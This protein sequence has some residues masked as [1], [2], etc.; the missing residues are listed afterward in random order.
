MIFA[1]SSL[2]FPFI[3]DP[4]FALGAALRA[5]IRR[6]LTQREPRPRS[7]AP[8]FSLF[9]P[10]AM[11]SPAREPGLYFSRLAHAPSTL[12]LLKAPKPSRE[13]EAHPDCSP[14][15]RLALASPRLGGRACYRPFLSSLA[16]LPLLVAVAAASSSIL[17]S[18][19]SAPSLPFSVDGGGGSLAS[20]FKNLRAALGNQP[21]DSYVAAYLALFGRPS[22]SYA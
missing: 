4:P 18:P 14:P 12:C 1:H 8:L 2:V 22:S 20:S 15:R 7:M 6:V 13:W 19:G 5:P 10:H 11:H 9:K 3:G 16:S 17:P 21:P